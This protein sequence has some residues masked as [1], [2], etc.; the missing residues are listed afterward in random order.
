MPAQ[1]FARVLES[2]RRHQPLA[3]TLFPVDTTG[4][5]AGGMA[6]RLPP[7][8]GRGQRQQQAHG[9]TFNRAAGQA[10]GGSAGREQPAVD[11]S[12]SNGDVSR[13]QERSW[14]A[15]AGLPRPGFPVQ[16][17]PAASPQKPST[18][19]ANGATG[20]AA[21]SGSATSVAGD[22]NY[23][24]ASE[25]AAIMPGAGD[26]KQTQQTAQQHVSASHQAL[27]A[28]QLE[29]VVEEGCSTDGELS[30]GAG[31]A[32]TSSAPVAPTAST[33]TATTSAQPAESPLA[34]VASIEAEALNSAAED[35][36]A[37]QPAQTPATSQQHEHASS[38]AA[39]RVTDD[40][41]AAY[42]DLQAASEKRRAEAPSADI[43]DG[44]DAALLAVIVE[45]ANVLRTINP[46]EAGSSCSL[47]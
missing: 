10:A 45:H 47:M 22:G 11:A 17:S 39:P 5:S 28:P 15:R 26:M 9:R 7:W 25:S 38:G 40:C 46:G 24:P 34:D 18:A 21:S 12:V 27:P 30:A 33:T 43:W 23:D 44:N 14:S 36:A 20:H 1:V 16:R 13:V 4:A 6:V 2:V 3:G 41:E 29:A 8:V 42:V 35:S 19:S 31:A 32:V 37:S